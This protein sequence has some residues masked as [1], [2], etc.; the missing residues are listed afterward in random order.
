MSRSIEHWLSG[1]GLGQ[2]SDAFFKND[3]DLDVVGDLSDDDLKELGLSLGHRKKLQRAVALLEAG[4]DNAAPPQIALSTSKV[5]TQPTQAERRHLTVMFVDLVG[6]T[7]MA[8]SLDPEEMRGVVTSYQNTVAGVVARYDGYVAKFMG[9]G[10]LCYFGWPNAHEDDAERATRAGLD[11]IASVQRLETPTETPLAARIGIA[12]GIVIVGD[13]IGDGASQ[14]AA[15]VGSTPN[16][17]ARLQGV[18]QPNQIVVAAETRALLGE[19]FRLE[20]TDAQDLKGFA[21]PIIAFAIAGEWARQSRFESR[22]GAEIGPIVGRDQEIAL[23]REAWREAQA[24]N[25]RMVM[26]TGEAGIG[27]SRITRAAIAEIAEQDHLRITYQCSPYHT[28]S[29]FYPITQN[30][31]YAAGIKSTDSDEEQLDR[32]E[33]AVGGVGRTPALVAALLGLDGESRYGAL[34]LTPA[35]QR[36]QIMDALIGII[37]RASERQPLLIVFEDLHW[38]DPTTLELLELALDRIVDRRVLVLAT[39]R[40]VFEYGFGGHP[41]VSRFALNRLGADQI[42][43]VV[44]RLTGGLPPPPEVLDIVVARTDGVPLFVEEL[45]KTILE[46]GV[47]KVDGDRMTLTGPLDRVAIPHTLHDSLMARLDR[48]QP[49]K[50]VAQTAACIGRE[51]GHRLLASVTLLQE[52]DLGAAL[53]NLISAEL[54][55]RRGV[56]P[57]ATY[58][59]KHALVRDA[60]YE[61]LLKD[62]RRVIHARILDALSTEAMVPPEL[63]AQHAEAAGLTDRAIDLWDR[64]S[65]AAIARPAYDE[66]IAQLQHTLALLREQIDQNKPGA[67]DRALV[68]Q[69]R[70]ANAHLARTGYGAAV[71]KEAFERALALADRIGDTPLRFSALYGLWVGMYVR[72]DHGAAERLAAELIALTEQAADTASLVVSIRIMGTSLL[73]QGK[74]AEAQAHF[75]RALGLFDPERHGGLEN[76]FGQDVGATVHLYLAIALLLGGRPCRAQEH[77]N[78]ALHRA[79]RSGHANTVCYTHMHRAIIGMLAE[80][81]GAIVKHIDVLEPLANEHLLTLWIEYAKLLR[82]S[83][84]ALEGA[85]VSKGNYVAADAE[86]VRAGTMLFLPLVRAYVAGRAMETGDGDWAMEM[87]AAAQEMIS[88]T[89]EL[90]FLPMCHRL[91]SAS[92]LRAGDPQ[93]AEIE[94]LQ[95]IDVAGRQ[96]SR[97][98]ELRAAVDLARLRLGQGR[99]ADAA[100]CLGPVLDGFEARDRPEELAAAEELLAQIEANP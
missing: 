78:E 96:R 8:A 23:I 27:K 71:T 57:E 74:V 5:E 95:A 37:E 85:E 64:A 25:G 52:S 88:S 99:S 4:A 16:L 60:A 56:P 59:F 41:V 29:A 73:L 38:I 26:V 34:G 86:V 68:L 21:E 100:A 13:L 80:D 67:V 31:A 70:L 1:L 48:L 39:A 11:S 90:L 63:A 6:S 92:A 77:I 84:P 89:G 61:S 53:E 66:G 58:L 55:Y 45:T 3:V 87:T 51:F 35:Q 47:M 69:V 10:V 72:G 19:V 76:R 79:D 42:N 82:A 18:A 46:S 30:L 65:E 40:P 98:F 44:T 28:E 75:E 12:T 20:K 33:Q 43:A 50:E 2:Y 15:V 94:L 81:P 93:T 24:G 22:Q 36:A 7:E 97:L 83:E 32:L 62:R 9:D 14:E 17:A 54:I 49:V 91:H